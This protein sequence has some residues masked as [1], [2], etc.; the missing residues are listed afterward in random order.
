MM[1]KF[2]RKHM[3]YYYKNENDLNTTLS[4]TDKNSRTYSE[5]AAVVI[6]LRENKVVKNEVPLD[7]IVD[8]YMD[9][10]NNEADRAQPLLKSVDREEVA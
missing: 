3:A 1:I 10:I 9:Q 6:D 7:K 8:V 5:L 2:V 4:V